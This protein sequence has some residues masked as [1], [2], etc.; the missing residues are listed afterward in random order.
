MLT[1]ALLEKQL[2]VIC[3][4]LGILSAAVLSLIPMIRP[5][6]WQ[7]LLLP[8]LPNKMLDFLDAPV[9]FIVSS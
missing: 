7:S 2:V 4:N 8:V 5:F 1:G 3:P 9:P 6:E